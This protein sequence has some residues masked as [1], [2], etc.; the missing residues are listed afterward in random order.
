MPLPTSAAA[1]KI[2]YECGSSVKSALA[3]GAK[4]YRKTS[5]QIRT[6]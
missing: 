1:H 6:L 5:E 2:K 3:N 4:T